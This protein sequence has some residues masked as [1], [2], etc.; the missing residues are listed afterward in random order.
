MASNLFNRLVFENNRKIKNRTFR[1]LMLRSYYSL[2]SWKKTLAYGTDDI[3]R[4]IVIETHSSCNRKCSYCPVSLYD[5][6]RHLMDEKLYR[7]IIDEL[8]SGKYKGDIGYH[9]F[10]E[11]LLD[12]RLESF[13]EYTR[14]KLPQNH[15]MI[16]TNGDF[17][18][19]ERYDSLLEAG[20]SMFYVTLH[21]EK[22]SRAIPK[23]LKT[24]P[25]K[26]RIA[27]R[28]LDTNSLLSS[29]GNLVRV[30]NKEIMGICG[31]P[32]N[33]LHIDYRGNI[34]LC[35]EDYFSKNVFGNLKEEKL[36]DIWDKPRFRK[37]RKETM[38]GRF[39]LKICKECT[40]CTS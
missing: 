33:T 17:L 34:V 16:Y 27:L 4:E 10:S 3:F 32:S 35:C 39:R 12:T 13:V 30:K 7:K 14:K 9:F 37:I 11:P 15:I 5:R 2:E 29:R 23:L 22:K 26:S 36:F 38:R 21:G 28:R 20:V 18:T 8:A 19:R 25:D 24:G 1:D 40:S 31:F 6:G